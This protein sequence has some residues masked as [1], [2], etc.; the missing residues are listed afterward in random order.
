VLSLTLS[1]ATVVG[2]DPLPATIAL[3]APAPAGGAIVTLAAADPISVP[4]SVTV[5][6]GQTSASFTLL[7][8]EVGGDI[9]GTITA[10]YGGGTAT[11]TLAVT[12]PKNARAAFGVTGPVQSETCTLSDNGNTLN[13]TFNGSESTAPGRITAWDWTYGVSST[14]S[15]TTNTEVLTN[16]AFDCSMIP[17][18][19]FPAGTTFLTMVVRLKVHDE[20]GN[21]SEEVSHDDIRLLPQ[22][23]CGY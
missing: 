10:T 17:P 11:A 21:V 7:T 5:S 20:L 8:R 13:C 12:R 6:A 18:A 16:P 15:Q 9:S 19:P 22:G 1:A 23:S 14:R 2:G 3:T 4:P